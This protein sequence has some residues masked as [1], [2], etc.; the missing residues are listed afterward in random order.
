MGKGPASATFMISESLVTMRE[1][2]YL[3]QMVEESEGVNVSEHSSW[4]RNSELPIALTLIEDVT[5]RLLWLE[6][7]FELSKHKLTVASEQLIYIVLVVIKTMNVTLW[8]NLRDNWYIHHILQ[9][10]PFQC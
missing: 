9:R 4:V 2:L 5:E 7:V 1:Q 3:F 6:T 8:V 10:R